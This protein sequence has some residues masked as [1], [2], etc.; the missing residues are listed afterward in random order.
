[1]GLS[2]LVL[3]KSGRGI[4]EPLGL[5]QCAGRSQERSSLQPLQQGPLK[6][7]DCYDEQ[8]QQRRHDQPPELGAPGG[9]Y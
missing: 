9:L 7:Q 8:A 6:G 4:K 2:C 3:L 1:M 5:L